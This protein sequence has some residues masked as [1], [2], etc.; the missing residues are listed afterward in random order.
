MALTKLDLDCF[1]DR[2]SSVDAAQ[3]HGGGMGHG[4]SHGT[5]GHAHRQ[6][7]NTDQ[8]RNPDSRPKDPVNGEVVNPDTAVNAMYQGRVYYFASRENRDTFEASPAQ[9]AA[10]TGERDEEHRHHRRGC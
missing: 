10:R 1:R 4:R 6:Q 3:R 8:P 5:D 7:E 2:R 9:Y